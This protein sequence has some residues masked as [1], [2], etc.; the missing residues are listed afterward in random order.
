MRSAGVNSCSDREAGSGSGFV[1]GFLA[2][3]ES[4]LGLDLSSFLGSGSGDAPLGAGLFSVR[5]DIGG[6]DGEGIEGGDEGADLGSGS[7]GQGG[8]LRRREGTASSMR[9]GMGTGRG[10]SAVAGMGGGW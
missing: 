3:G 5:G 4:G 8:G 6:L 7:L 2:D 9:A 10:R 1:P